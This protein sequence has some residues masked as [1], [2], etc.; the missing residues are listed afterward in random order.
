MRQ[1]L[2]GVALLLL[3]PA[4]AQAAFEVQSFS[5]TP[6]SLQAG[7]HP[8]VGIALGFA[9]DEHVRDLTLSLPPGLVGN[10]NATPRCSAANFQGDA[11]A[12]NTRIGSTSVQS[13]ILGLPVTA[14]GDV[15]NLQPG[16][17]EPA[18]LGVIVRPPLGADKVFL[19]SRV[20]LRPADG[21]LDSIITGIPSTVRV[22]GLE[23]EMSIQSMTLT[24]Q[25]RFMTMPTGCAPATAR[26]TAT[27]ANGTVA[28]RAAAPFT[29][30]DCSKLP[31]APQFSGTISNDRSPSLRTVITG[32]VGNA[33]TASAAV[34]LP[35]GVGVDLAVAQNA[36][37]LEQQAAG[38]CPESA[39]IGSAVAESP[40]LPPLTGPVFL[41]ALPG[42]PLPGVRVDLAGAVS[43]SLT[44]TVS[45]GS[46][47]RT[48][49]SGIPDV[50]LERFEL[51]FDG[52]RALRTTQDLCRG[53]LPR[54]SAELT[55]HNGAT[56]ALRVPLT[57]S[58]CRK[59]VAGL[60]VHGRK[61]VLRVRAARGGPALQ[62]VQLRLPGRLH[63][64]Q[65]RGR[66]STGARLS[67]RGVLTVAAA[68]ARRV[69]ATLSRGAFTGRLG[70]RRTFSLRT[71]DVTGHPEAQRI[72]A[73]R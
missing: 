9:G 18:R 50:P 42:R 37:T 40:L 62:R 69:T 56:A 13:T 54:M 44:G 51:T 1:L 3:A 66:I 31:F 61:L 64:H 33:N 46:G 45:L 65:R 19:I 39:R 22:L 58:G 26:A 32:P 4:T 2:L 11:C 72:R 5:V 29:P 20:A 21:G 12:A 57:V 41:A 63:A 43:L 52:G 15:Y 28:N 36:C 67:R 10:P 27:S 25:G 47:L 24:L 17:A 35:K 59:P 23:Q 48:Q 55:G 14:D 38:P 34:T 7:S 53:P 8:D 70:K 60:R 73:R 49:F 71:V 16:P 30:T 6:S 68:G